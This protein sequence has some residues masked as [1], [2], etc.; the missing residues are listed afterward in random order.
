MTEQGDMFDPFNLALG[1]AL[2]TMGMKHAATS[3]KDT[4]ELGKLL[5]RQAA[6]TRSNKTATAD[7]ASRGFV[8]LGLPANCLGAASGSLF[9]S[10]NWSF[11]G[12]WTKSK[13]VT[14][15]ASD[16]RIWKLQE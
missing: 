2:K 14:N 10:N 7:D 1:E 16:L 11:T 4:L 6:K 8:A 3:K 12:Q 5:C 9:R 15:H 13:R